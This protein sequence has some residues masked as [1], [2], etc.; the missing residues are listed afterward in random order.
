MT[1]SELEID[2]RGLMPPEPL[3]RTL[4]AIAGTEPGGTVVALMDREPLLLYPELERR[5]CTW[6][7]E[8]DGDHYKITIRLPSP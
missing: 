6:T 3:V 5:D 2:N 7:F 8:E 4:A 1:V